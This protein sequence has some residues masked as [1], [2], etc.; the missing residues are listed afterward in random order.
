MAL[1]KS[2]KSLRRWTKQKWRTKSGK[3]P[4]HFAVEARGANYDAVKMLLDAYPSG[5]GESSER[6]NPKHF[7]AYLH[8]IEPNIPTFKDKMTDGQEALKEEVDM[9]LR[10][11]RQRGRA[12]VAH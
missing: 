12:Q 5:A 3:L 9:A 7:P 6:K 2:Q 4:L 1:K 10:R 8:L 11:R